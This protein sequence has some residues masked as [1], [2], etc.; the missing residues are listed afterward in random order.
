[1][2]SLVTANETDK[3]K[4]SS[5]FSRFPVSFMPLDSFPRL[6]ISPAGHPYI[7]PPDELDVK[8]ERAASVL[9]NRLRGAFQADDYCRGL[10]HLATVELETVLPGDFDFLRTFAKNYLTQLC[11]LPELGVTN[12]KIVLELPPVATPS[13]SETEFLL[14]GAPP[15]PG[16]EYLT[17]DVLAEWWRSLDHFVHAQ[18]KKHAAGAVDW[19][20]KQSPL[21]RTVGRVT[22]HLAENKRDEAR[23]ARRSG[24]IQARKS[25][26]DPHGPPQ[27][28]GVACAV[29]PG[30]GLQD[31]LFLAPN[32]LY[33]NDE[34]DGLLYALNDHN[35]RAHVESIMGTLLTLYTSASVVYPMR[36]KPGP[37]PVPLGG[38]SL[39]EGPG[40]PC[41]AKRRLRLNFIP[42]ARSRRR[43]GPLFRRCPPRDSPSVS[44]SGRCQGLF[45]LCLQ[46]C[47]RLYLRSFLR[48]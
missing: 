35:R 23:P 32:M 8:Q 38:T 31:S 41:H 15:M 6:S 12:G 24:R 19:I 45:R 42:T 2:L 13:D 1:M 47:L 14:I 7:G 36:R 16:A 44:C 18:I 48:P 17:A 4:G 30:E 40:G 33:Q 39:F 11:H 5:F 37:Q 3:M 28:P 46:L 21:W 25:G 22:F 26:D 9:E 29:R 43:K 20:Q 27:C 34:I 10:L